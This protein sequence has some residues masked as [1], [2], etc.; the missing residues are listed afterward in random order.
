MRA[1][2]DADDKVRIQYSSKQASVSNYWKYYIGQVAQLKKNRV[3]E[4]KQILEKE[5]SAWVNLNNNRKE[6]YGNCLRDIQAAYEQLSEYETASQYFFEAVYGG[7]EMIKLAFLNRR[8]QNSIKNNFKN[9]D[10][11]AVLAEKKEEL[12]RHF[13]DY[14][15]PL[16][17]KVFIEMMKMYDENIGET[18]K[19]EYFI[20]TLKKCKGDYNKMAEMIFDKSVF[21]DKSKMMELC[22]SPTSFESDPAYLLMNSFLTAYQDISLKTTEANSMLE[23][24]NR[25][26]IAGLR[27][28]NPEV[29]YYPDANS[30]M[31]LTY[32]TVEDYFPADGIHYDF[33]TTMKGVMEKEIPNDWEFHVPKK[34]KDIYESK[35]YGIYGSNGELT[36]NFITNNDITGGNSGSPVIDGNGYLIG[37]AFDG[38]WE[39]MSGDINFEPNLQRTI[40][41]DSRYLLLVIDK[42]ANAQNIMDELKIIK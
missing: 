17:R 38:N 41:M 25:L 29:I 33:Q 21:S 20:A 31:R 13:K 23:R 18:F 28:M 22:I 32:G 10:K 5:F 35:D 6:L 42:F 39:A 11:E 40:S 14:Y 15:R 3:V 19:S 30:T 1:E 37:L 2:M 24:G 16:D 9:E 12:E 7:S 4:K 27:E 26:F 34:L 8:F 36:V